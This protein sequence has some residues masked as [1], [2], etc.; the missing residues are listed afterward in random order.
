M[1]RNQDGRKLN[2]PSSQ[3]SSLL[4]NLA[5]SLL[6]NENIVT[7]DTKA[8]ELRSFVEKLISFV[9]PSPI[10]CEPKKEINL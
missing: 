4:R 10:Y 1:S 6:D 3:R 8:K 9:D 2:C 5:L 7:T